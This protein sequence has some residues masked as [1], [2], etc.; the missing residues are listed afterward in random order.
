MS[1]YKNWTDLVVDY[2]KKNGED[3]F[4]EEYSSIEKKIYTKLLYDHQGNIK[5]SIENLAVAFQVEPV[6]FTG[7]LDGINESLIN[8]IEL[9]KVEKDVEIEINI[10]YEKLYFN[11]VDAKADYLYTL[12]QW[13]SI[14]SKEKRRDIQFSYRDTKTT[15]NKNKIGR[16]DPC[17]CGSG[18]KYKKCCGKEA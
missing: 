2:V 12:P 1:L 11:M 3:A 4:W 9:E 5:D 18:K 16:N 7:F 10:D 17:L 13:D 6:Y 14:F 15:V 8:K